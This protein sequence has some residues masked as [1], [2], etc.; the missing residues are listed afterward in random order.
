MKPVLH[1]FLTHLALSK[2]N[3]SQDLKYPLTLYYKLK[4]P[5]P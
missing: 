2:N 5:F 4:D 1:Y 3:T